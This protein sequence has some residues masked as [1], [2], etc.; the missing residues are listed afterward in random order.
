MEPYLLLIV[1]KILALERELT[2]IRGK[3]PIGFVPTMGA[4]HEGHMSLIKQSLDNKCFTVCSIFVNPTQFN[5]KGDLERYPR[6][7]ELDISLLESAGC[8]LL[9]MP[10]AEEVYPTGVKIPSFELGYLETVLE[11]AFRPGHFKGVAQVV[12]RLFELVRPDQAF[13]GRKD[14]QQLMIIRE[15]VRLTGNQVKIISGE[16]L[17]EADGLAMSSRNRL[18]T[19]EQR[20]KVGII[21]KTLIAAGKIA[22]ETSIEK[23]SAFV[24]KEI[25]ALEGFQL[26]YFEIRE[27][28]TLLIPSKVSSGNI[29]L[30]ALFVGKIR[31]IDNITID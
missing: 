28:E 31:L 30:I 15:L 6:T 1:S 29:A 17:R 7:P 18:L 11:G 19:K 8:D 4:L 26:E 12:N 2:Q 25:N 10:D 9:F 27:A 14:F 22:K 16:T 13:F 5:D 20:L 3:R 21:Y 23:A 24:A